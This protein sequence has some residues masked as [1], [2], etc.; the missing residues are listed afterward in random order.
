MDR[1]TVR[2]MRRHWRVEPVILELQVEHPDLPPVGDLPDLTGHEDVDGRRR[3]AVTVEDVTVSIDGL[4]QRDGTD[5][6]IALPVCSST[7]RVRL[8]LVQPGRW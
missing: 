2:T 6:T 3:V 5:L 1:R 7:S 8:Q 4:R